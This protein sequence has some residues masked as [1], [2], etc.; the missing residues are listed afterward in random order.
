MPFPLDEDYGLVHYDIQH[1]NIIERMDDFVIIDVED[2]YLAPV[3]VASGQTSF[4]LLRHHL[5]YNKVNSKTEDVS[6][7]PSLLDKVEKF[8][9]L[10]KRIFSWGLFRTMHDISNI[11]MF[12]MENKDH[13]Y[14]YDLEKKLLFIRNTLRF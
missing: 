6:A 14:L 12:A 11:V 5:R 3:W 2:I 10:N 8:T 13:S 7:V 1:S 4:R 9:H